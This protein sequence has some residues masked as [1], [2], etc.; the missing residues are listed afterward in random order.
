MVKLRVKYGSFYHRNV[1]DFFTSGYDMASQKTFVSVL[2]RIPN[3]GMS[4][5]N[6]LVI[7][8]VSVIVGIRLL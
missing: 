1:G 4:V 2:R 3:V 7:S 8:V 5:S 6:R